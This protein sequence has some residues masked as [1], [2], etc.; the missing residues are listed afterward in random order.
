MSVRS[1]AVESGGVDFVHRYVVGD[2]SQFDTLFLEEGYR[3]IEGLVVDTKLG[4]I[5][6]RNHSIP[7]SA[8]KWGTEW[9]ED[10]LFIEP[11]TMCAYTN[12]TFE[13]SVPVDGLST[14]AENLVLVDHG[15]FANM[16]TTFP[17]LEIVTAQDDPQLAY[18]AYRSAWFQNAYTALYYNITNPG[19][20]ISGM[21]S[22]SYM[23]SEV[24]KHFP[25]T[26]RNFSAGRSTWLRRKFSVSEF[27]GYI[28]DLPS[29]LSNGSVSNSSSSF[30][31][32]LPDN[33]WQITSSNFTDAQSV[34]NGIF[35]STRGNISNI[36]GFCGTA[37]GIPQE[38]GAQNVLRFE[39]GTSYTQPLLGCASVMRAVI[40]TVSFRHN[41][42]GLAGL[43]VTDIREKTYENQESMPLWGVESARMRMD[44][45]LPLW[46]IIDKAKKDLYTNMT[47][48]EKPDLY[49]SGYISTS[50]GGLSP[51]VT[52]QNIAGL[53][54]YGDALAFAYATGSNGGNGFFDYSG[55][56]GLGVYNRWRNMSS[57]A[58][59]TARIINLIWTD[60][61]ANS[62]VGTKSWL[63]EAGALV[64]R[65][66]A[67]TP[68]QALVPV[69]RYTRRVRYHLA[70][71]IPAF[72]VLAIFAIAC[73]LSFVLAVFGEGTPGRMKV[74]L[75]KTSVGRV[76]TSLLH[77]DTVTAGA[78]TK[79]WSERLGR[80]YIDFVGSVPRGAMAGQ[81]PAAAHSDI[82]DPMLVKGG[83][84]IA[85]QEFP[86]R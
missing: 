18:R 17:E 70:Y 25:Q 84:S 24:D 1:V 15:G 8:S 37:L 46:G 34:C 63:P 60:V 57:T 10:L 56:S 49:L 27:G 85:L 5:G 36:L 32:N 69:Q 41:G 22:F 35:P 62:V 72:I 54:F 11:Q 31:L 21:K 53:N 19:P 66:Q 51:V 43:S 73:T 64:K 16:N 20:S 12:L 47:F 83:S 6:F 38:K 45:G 33:P 2:F 59:G 67:S 77:P 82:Y 7:A 39:P 26:Q 13:W 58:E 44:D 23:D 29:S 14:D 42:T 80:M 52:G 79:V 68:Q 65:Q 61:A 40:K 78:P 9:T 28:E 86:R 30:T 74:F 3:V 48:A 50:S 71:A 4:S 55:E 75:I 76:M 81:H